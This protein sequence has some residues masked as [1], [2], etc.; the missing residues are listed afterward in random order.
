MQLDRPRF[1][2]DLVAEPINEAGTR[3]IDVMDPDSG[4]VFRFFEVEYSL[5]CGMDGER[6][7]PGIVQWAKEELGL[8]P[9]PSEVQVVIA[10]LGEL[11]YLDKAASS[12]PEDFMHPGVVVGQKRAHTPAP[13]L[14]L[15]NAGA[16]APTAAP[17]AMPVSNIELSP[18]V[19]AARPSAAKSSGED[20]ALGTPGRS[21]LSTDL[22]D[23]VGVGVEDVKAAVRASQVMKAVDVPPELA[24]ALEDPKPKD[25]PR[26]RNTPPPM[27]VV[28]V[29]ET[30]P[31]I[32]D[33]K[34]PGPVV[35][36][37]KKSPAADVKATSKP[38]EAAQPTAKAVGKVDAMGATAPIAKLETRPAD[39][40]PATAVEA[41]KKP[42]APPAPEQQTS[43]PLLVLLVVVAIAALAFVAYRYLMKPSSPTAT[44]PVKPPM[45]AVKPPPPPAPPPVES[46]KLVTTPEHTSDVKPTASGRIETLVP[47]G[48]VAADA[49]IA[50]FAGAKPLQTEV[51]ALSKDVEKRLPGEIDQAQKDSDAATSANA[52]AAAQARLADR[53]KSLADKQAKLTAKQADL[54][55]LEIKAPSSGA[56]KA[57]SKV[58]AQVTANDAVFSLTQPALRIATFAKADGATANARVLLVNKADGKQ[59]SCTVASVDPGAIAIACPTDVAAE[60]ADVT[61]GGID[62]T[63]PPVVEP[64]AGSAAATPAPAPA[65]PAPRPH[66]PTPAPKQKAPAG[67]AAATD[68]E[69]PPA[70]D[71]PTPAPAG[72]AAP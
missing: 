68:T 43:R 14:E 24:A 22:S 34:K 59:L 60:G 30:K 21:D 71:T 8:V 37:A 65:P 5:A 26:P 42:S 63:P 28:K 41:H 12:A 53:Q 44:A 33:A 40:K 13:D 3:F 55:K 15:G 4:N 25:L 72:S 17:K 10:T 67:S 36:D 32:V 62:T 49:V 56:V 20:I 47:D 45:V 38:A 35:V 46:H 54:D 6:D 9:S 27:P 69:A 7:V 23:Q 61:Y 2:Q 52:R 39:A 58:G 66:A 1:R 51:A 18:G 19:T 31:G 57:K 64:P 70:T 16:S 48:Q 29:P 11:G 50:T